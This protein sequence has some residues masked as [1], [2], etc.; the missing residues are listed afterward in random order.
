MAFMRQPPETERRPIRPPPDKIG[1]W[2]V[3][4]QTHSGKLRLVEKQSGVDLFWRQA[5]GTPLRGTWH[6]RCLC[7]LYRSLAAVCEGQDGA[8][9]EQYHPLPTNADPEEFYVCSLPPGIYVITPGAEPEWQ[10]IW[11]YDAC[12]LDE[13]QAQRERYWPTRDRTNATPRL[14]PEV[15][16]KL[17]SA[18]TK[19]TIKRKTNPIIK[20]RLKP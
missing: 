11:W 2:S 6:M 5:P 19:P 12:W 17:R 15:L 20:L 14:P 13:V 16:A 3:L 10:L 18:P 4:A 7:E 9:Y 8:S 1:S